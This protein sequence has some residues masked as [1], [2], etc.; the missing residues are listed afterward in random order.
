M[1]VL[2]TGL[3]SRT[4]PGAHPPSADVFLPAWVNLIAAYL[5]IRTALIYFYDCLFHG[6]GINDFWGAVTTIYNVEEPRFDL[7]YEPITRI[8][9]GRL[10]EFLLLECGVLTV[11]HPDH[12]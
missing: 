8:K 10:H 1:F 9:A 5:A 11:L 12:P 6:L 3:H 4:A 7:C 2:P